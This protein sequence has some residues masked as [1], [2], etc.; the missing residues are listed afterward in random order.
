MFFKGAAIS[1]FTFLMLDRS[2]GEPVT[3]GTITATVS[4]DGAAPSALADTPVHLS[5]GV[6]KVDLSAAEMNADMV[7]LTFSHDNAITVHFTI[8]TWD[9]VITGT[10][11]KTYTVYEPDGTT[12]MSACE[13][14]ATSD[15]AGTLEIANRGYTDDLG[16]HTFYFN[17]PVGTTVYIWSRKAGKSFTNPD[18]E[19]V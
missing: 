7:G 12:P 1:G 18:S 17:V 13:V 3:S 2:T 8:R 10:T 9:T 11:A 15:L 5:V 4:H 19:V 6:W 16:Q 14:W